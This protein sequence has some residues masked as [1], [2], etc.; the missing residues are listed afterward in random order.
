[1][2]SSKLRKYSKLQVNNI[3]IVFGEDLIKFN[4]FTELKI[5]EDKLDDE[6]KL[7]PAYYGFLVTVHKKLTTR[8]ESLKQERKRLYSRLYLKA[9]KKSS[10]GRP[11]ND[12]M[13]KAEV[14]INPQYVRITKNCIQAKDEADTIY[15]ALKGFE[16]RKDLI[17]TL[18]SNN[19]KFT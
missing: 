3:R 5:N 7:Q 15:A 14:E 2:G 9:K 17:Q 8:F 19:R 10:G 6:I 1:M 11:Y 4:L 12:E 18:S 13:A 16:Q